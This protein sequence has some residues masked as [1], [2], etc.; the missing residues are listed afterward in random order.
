MQ[1]IRDMLYKLVGKT[2]LSGE[3]VSRVVKNL[4]GSR[5]S[6]ALTLGLG[7]QRIDFI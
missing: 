3:R 1:N 5:P 2:C 4:V 6:F 7:A